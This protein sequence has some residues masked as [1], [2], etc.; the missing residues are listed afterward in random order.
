[1]NKYK[2]VPKVAAQTLIGLLTAGAVAWLTT[3]GVSHDE[4][5]QLHQTLTEFLVACIP[6]AAGFAAGWLKTD[7]ERV[8]FIQ[9]IARLLNDLNK[10]GDEESRRVSADDYLKQ[11]KAW[12][13]D[14]KQK[15]DLP[16]S[17]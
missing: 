14:P 4:A 8:N 2:P 15:P 17:R 13:D 7:T 10:L 6:I 16:D 5:T 3:Q 12:A 11:V 1:M 9:T